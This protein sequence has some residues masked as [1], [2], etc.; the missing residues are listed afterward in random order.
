MN[1]HFTKTY[2]L[3]VSKERQQ[4]GETKDFSLVARYNY[5]CGI[6]QSYYNP[7]KLVATCQRWTVI[8]FG[9]PPLNVCKPIHIETYEY[10]K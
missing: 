7:T 9:N 1:P 10:C 3:T 5:T 2:T 6:V 8:R 4:R